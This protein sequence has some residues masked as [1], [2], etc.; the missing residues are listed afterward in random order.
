MEI[1]AIILGAYGALLSTFLG[2]REILKDRSQ[3]L[4]SL[5]VVHTETGHLFWYSIT[6]TGHRP[7]TIINISILYQLKTSIRERWDHL[8]DETLLGPDYGHSPLPCLIPEGQLKEFKLTDIATNFIDGQ[9]HPSRMKL[10]ALD[11]HGKTYS[12]KVKLR[13]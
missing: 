13:W 2:I 8:G 10:V 6:N 1:I 3:V 5:R 9:L 11:A 7:L 12:Q 4:L